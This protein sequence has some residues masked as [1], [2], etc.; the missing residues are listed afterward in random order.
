MSRRTVVD[1]FPRP[2]LVHGAARATRARLLD[3]FDGLFASGT[4][5]V[6]VTLEC[7]APSLPRELVV[8]S[9]NCGVEV[10]AA[11]AAGFAVRAVRVDNA[12]RLDIEDLT[13]A[14]R[15]RP[16]A[17]LLIHYFGFEPPER[18]AVAA[19]CRAEG[20]PL[21]EDCAHAL[22]PLGDGRSAALIGDAATFS[23]RK[24][25]PLVDGGALRI[26]NA[27]VVRRPPA[28]Q[29]AEGSLRLAARAS[30]RQL[31]GDSLISRLR[32]LSA[33]EGITPP[34]IWNTHR[35]AAPQGMS[36]FSRR[37]PGV[38]S[39]DLIATLRRTRFL[40]LAAA[41]ER[42][43][44]AVV[45]RRA[46][47][48]HEVP[49]VVPVVVRDRTAALRALG[50]TLIRP[51]VFGEHA[52]PATPRGQGGRADELRDAVLGLPVHQDIGAR[53]WRWLVDTLP[54]LLTPFARPWP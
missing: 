45:P 14:L 44:V 11:C 1:A 4:D 25:L 19:L 33:D 2:R 9:Y 39:P 22:F 52:H 30:A 8:P 28:L 41:L 36:R 35:P 13:R 37:L 43:G 16:A 54:T 47:G 48:A 3:H 38:A 42:V 50:R 5:A 40:E 7:L 23:L 10:E 18:E 34:P 12:M 29:H 15:A 24:F 27:D 51:Y 6:R 53:D 20:V 46:L 17:V 49:L 21:I 32:G 26:G 31:V